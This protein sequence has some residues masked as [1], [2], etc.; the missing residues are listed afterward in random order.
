MIKYFNFNDNI[1]MKNN[2][3]N[4]NNY[5]NYHNYHKEYI[6]YRDKYANE[7][8]KINIDDIIN[9]MNHKKQLYQQLLINE[10]INVDDL[11]KISKEKFI[12]NFCNKIKESNVKSY[13]SI[14][15]K[16]KIK[17][18]IGD[19][20]FLLGDKIK[21][22]FKYLDVGCNDGI[23]TNAIANYFKFDQNNVYGVDIKSW[24][25]KE[26]NCN[27]KNMFFVNEDNPELAY[28]DNYFDFITCFQVLHHNKNVYK[29]INELKRVLKK[30]GYLVI[31]EHD[32]NSLVG[33]EFIDFEHIKY[34]CIEEMD[35]TFKNYI[36]N[37]KSK[38]EWD[39]LFNLK[40]VKS[41]PPKGLTRIYTVAYT[42]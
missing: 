17:G 28:P 41:I 32:K 35:W 40:F 13:G 4:Y 10:N 26:N 3:H 1:Y 19:L 23:I 33:K 31:R 36:G 2:Y 21:P 6:K 34:L 29:M 5:N 15:M 8:N 37:Y 14:N 9:D 25:G 38:R 7:K 42:T 27:V 11:L 30:G 39:E 12:D 24:S 22:T 20:K 18:K 16:K